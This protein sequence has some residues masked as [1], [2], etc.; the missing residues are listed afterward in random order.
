MILR[1]YQQESVD[2][3]LPR[4]RGFVQAPAGSGKTIIAATAVARRAWTGCKVIWLANTR[5]QVEQGISAIQRTDGPQG[6]EFDVCCVAAQPDTSRADIIVVDECH[7][8]PAKSWMA[9]IERAKPEA[10]I[11]GFSATPFD[12]TKPERDQ[13]IRD[14][15]VDFITI[16]RARV[17]ASGHLEKGKVYV[18]DL[19][20]PG[21]FDPEIDAR[22]DFEVG[23][24]MKKFPVLRDLKAYWQLTTQLKQSSAALAAIKGHA[25]L[26]NAA[27]G[28]VDDTKEPEAVQK[29][30]KRIR[31][32][33]DERTKVV[34][35]EH[36]RRVR[37]QFTQDHLQ[38]HAG[39]NSAAIG[40]ARQEMSAGQSV[41]I[42]VH[43][44]EHGEALEQQIQGSK[45]VHSKIGAKTRKQAISDFRDGTLRCM[46]ATSLADEGLDVPRASRLILLSGGR[47]AGKLE[48]RAGRV[49][50][51]APGKSGGIIH[52][53]LDTGA[54]FAHAQAK[55][56]I[57]TYVKLGYDPEVVSYTKKAA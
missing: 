1:D 22:T 56:R 42:L 27:Q 16:D 3:L 53:F 52:D 28:F 36:A 31:Q 4:R 46:I 10:I 43:A 12:P 34:R 50:R 8:S 38:A 18:H 39:R 44:I 29:L 13:Y 19:D 2:F 32:L 55:A 54:K 15:F 11:W 47:S 40:L 45:L 23:I 14:T 41:L 35:E 5:E 51:P 9:L 37:W 20:E 21:Q 24:R 25:W 7:R 26:A 17:E 33:S 6:V 48:Q 49:L 57:R 30:L